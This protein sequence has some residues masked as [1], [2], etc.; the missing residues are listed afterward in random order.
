MTAN[1][2]PSV[3]PAEGPAYVAIVQ[4]L[5]QDIQA[6]RLRP[7]DRLPTQRDLA[8]QLGVALGT[9]TR[10]Y[11]EAMGRGLIHSGGRL[12]TF[13]GLPDA[14][15]ADFQVKESGEAEEVIN[16]AHNYPATLD[17][18][19]LSEA[20]RELAVYQHSPYL[21]RYTT[22]EGYR[23]HRQAGAKWAEMLGLKVNSDRVLPSAGAQQAL[24]AVLLTLAKPGDAIAADHLTYPG[25]KSL[26]SLFRMRLLPIA[27][28][29][30]GII[31]DELER[32]A[33]EDEIKALY[34][35]P[36]LNNPTNAIIPSKRRKEI[37][38]IAKRRGMMIIEDEIYRALVESPPAMFAELEPDRTFL[39]AS[40]SKIIAGGLRA[41]FIIPPVEYHERLGNTLYTL[42]LNISHLPLE[43]VARWIED[44]T[45]GRIIDRRR[46]DA[47]NRQAIARECLGPI[48]LT[49]STVSYSVWLPLPAPWT[50]SAFVSEARRRGVLLSG[51]DIFSAGDVPP[52][53]AVRMCLSAAPDTN[54]LRSALDIIAKLLSQTPR[55]TGFTI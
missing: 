37:A 16:L 26:C 5:E 38:R 43:I 21:L 28:D 20:F 19:D 8:E 1:W 7:G 25:I 32:A 17:N 55:R 27:S 12:G 39:V 29:A 31:P 41:G 49:D 44:G 35:V 23:R 40:V 50:A 54:R 36:T 30:E 13:V 9:V 34:V 15:P 4:A 47:V 11:N 45:V 10:A 3:K 22:P 2:V 51:S 46:R 24:A 53:E 14:V 18:P 48:G 42:N 6:G 52:L 33:Q